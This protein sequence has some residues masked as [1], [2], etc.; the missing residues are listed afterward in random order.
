MGHARRL[1]QY[2]TSGVRQS[3]FYPNI[4]AMTTTIG[5]LQ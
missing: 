2:L 5:T 4:T 1:L 3:R